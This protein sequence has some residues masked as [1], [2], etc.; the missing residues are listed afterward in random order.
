MNLEA[1]VSYVNVAPSAL[2]NRL[3]L[4]ELREDYAPFLMKIIA[5]DQQ[6]KKTQGKRRYS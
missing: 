2:R 4:T 3:V 6:T 1:L 5:F